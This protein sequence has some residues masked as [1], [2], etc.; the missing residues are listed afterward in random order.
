MIRQDRNRG[1]RTRAALCTLVAI[2]ATVLGTTAATSGAADSTVGD[3]TVTTTTVGDT[4]TFTLRV[5][6]TDDA[7]DQV[8]T[9]TDNDTKTISDIPVGTSCTVTED[10]AGG[11]IRRSVPSDGTVVIDADGEMVAFTNT[12]HL[13]DL[14]IN[15]T[16][17]GG[18]GTFTFRVDCTRDEFD[19]TVTITDSGSHTITG[20]PTRTECTVT[21]DPAPGFTTTVVPADGHVVIDLDGETVDFTN[22]AIPKGDLV[23]TK[24]TIGGTG[25]FTFHVDCTDDEFDQTVTITDSGTHTIT[26]IP[27][28][29]EC[30][31]TEEPATG[32]TTTVTPADGRVT[33]DLDGET[34]AFTNTAVLEP[35]LSITKTADAPAVSAGQPIGFTVTVA[36]SGQTAALGVTLNDPLPGGTGLNWAISPD[37]TGP[38]TC[39]VTGTPPSQTLAC[40]FGDMAPGA[41]ASV[42]LSSA[43][44][45]DTAGTFPNT[46]TARARNH[47]EVSGTASINVSGPQVAGAVIERPNDPAVLGAV[48]NRGETLPRTGVNALSMSLAGAMLIFLGSV[49]RIWGRRSH[50]R[51]ASSRRH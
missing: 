4:G 31:V 8:F 7:F 19:Q 13:A 22:T 15:K 49:F 32:F 24:S 45:S 11:F 35:A 42:H 40:S 21:E 6:C 23:V 48:V 41:S 37:Y 34:V 46:A 9:L 2:V 51:L 33:I 18:T 38:G 44:S 10:K 28:R 30:T 26:G 17:T 43:T 14:V 25:T 16:T 20:I 36:S 39:S 12:R 1:P 50:L 29:T 5:D 47:P 3:L 27:T